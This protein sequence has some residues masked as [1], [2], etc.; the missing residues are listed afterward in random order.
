MLTVASDRTVF[1]VLEAGAVAHP[2]RELLVFED[3]HGS[4][5]RWS[6]AQAVEQTLASAQWLRAQGVGP[7]DRV[8]LHLP[9]RPEFL[10]TWWAAARLGAVIVPTNPLSSRDELRYMVTYAQT[11]FS[12]TDAG[13]RA[14]VADLVAPGRWHDCDETPLLGASAAVDELP[15]GPPASADLAVMY[16]SGTTSRPKGVRVTHANYVYA[17]EVVAKAIALR[18][19]DRFLVVLPLFH[20]NAQYYATLSTLVAGGTLVMTTGFSASGYVDV[21]R[22]HRATVGSLFAAPI[23]M[24]IAKTPA[25]IANELRVVLFAQNLSADELRRWDELVGAPLLQLY[26]MTETMGPPL[27]NPLTGGR[28]DAIG[29]PVLGYA[30]RIV[31]EHGAPALTGELHVGGVP[32]V[33]LT[34]GYLDDPDATSAALQ[35]GWLRTGDIVRRDADGFVRFVDRDKDMI[36]RAGENVA[37]GEVE[38]AL[39]EH[40]GVTDVAVVGVPDPVRDEQIVAFVVPNEKCPEEA[41]LIGWCAERLARFRVPSRIVAIAELPRTSVGKVRKNELRDSWVADQRRPN[42]RASVVRNGR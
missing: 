26:G 12:L 33:S 19:D 24:L 38:A 37:A 29:R 30:V 21:A 41:Q 32:G 11:V 4:V 3:A 28:R 2:D 9:N 22:R 31:D 27:M 35:D 15:E 23:R 34:P 25:P 1:G 10:F 14:A 5:N 18:G 13:G 36:K 17:G 20:A 6:W 42:Q 39:R 16:T 7:R 40:P 8:H